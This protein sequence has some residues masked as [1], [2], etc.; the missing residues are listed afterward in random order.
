M[1]RQC[2]FSCSWFPRWWICRRPRTRHDTSPAHTACRGTRRAPRRRPGKLRSGHSFA[3]FLSR[4][5][6]HVMC[7]SIF[8]GGRRMGIS[9]TIPVTDAP[10]HTEMASVPCPGRL[11]APFPGCPS[12]G[13]LHRASPPGPHGHNCHQ[14]TASPTALGPHA[15]PHPQLSAPGPASCSSSQETGHA[16]VAC[17]ISAHAGL[18]SES[19][20]LALLGPEGSGASPSGAILARWKRVG[21]GGQALGGQAAGCPGTPST[22]TPLPYV[23]ASDGSKKGWRAVP[24]PAA[25]EQLRPPGTQCGRKRPR[26]HSR[27]AAQRGLQSASFPHHAGPATRTPACW[28][29]QC[30]DRQTPGS[31]GSSGT[32]TTVFR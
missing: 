23:W 11:A 28:W 18:S 19:H 10:L 8:R 4:F 1:S 25:Q 7:V 14:G 29:P 32:Q 16:C 20:C 5:E 2:W 13:C 21:R 30:T 3:R 27:A 31:S 15:V 17:L 12:S 24:M 26:G 22:H 9:Y 6:A